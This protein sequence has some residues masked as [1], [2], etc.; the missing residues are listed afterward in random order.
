MRTI[1][2]QSLKISD[3]QELIVEVLSEFLSVAIQNNDIC[4]WYKCTLGAQKEIRKI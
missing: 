3:E 2:K 1:H 4:I